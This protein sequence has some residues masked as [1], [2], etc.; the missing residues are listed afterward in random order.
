MPEHSIVGVSD[1]AP[2]MIDLQT[3][4]C[5]GVILASLLQS[6]RKPTSSEL[7]EGGA[8]EAESGA[9]D[10]LKDEAFEVPIVAT[11]KPSPEPKGRLAVDVGAAVVLA[12]V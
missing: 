12:L 7:I 8:P 10:E 11:L 6:I 5:K 1:G 9:A 3:D 4:G 2:S